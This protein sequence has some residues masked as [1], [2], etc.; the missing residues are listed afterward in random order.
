[1]FR[2]L[3]I[4]SVILVLSGLATVAFAQQAIPEAVYEIFENSCAFAGCHTGPSSPK[5][6]DLSEDFMMSSL[7]NVPSK[8][9]PGVLRLKPGDPANSYLIMKLKGSPGIEGG[10]MPKKS[11]PLR[12]SDMAALESWIESMEPTEL[13]V[14][15]PKRKYIQA[16]PGLSLAT[17]PTTET[18]DKGTFSYRIAH[19]W[20]GATREGFDRLFGL[21]FGAGMLTQL[22]FPITNDLMVLTARS[23]ENATFEFAGKWR[24][25]REKS[26]ASV[27]LSAAVKVGVDWATLKDIFH[28]D[29]ANSTLSRTD[30]ERFHWFAQLILSKQVHER[31]SLLLVPG[32][33]LNGNVNVSDEDPILTLGFVGK[34]KLFEGFSVFVEG[35]PILSGESDA[36][37]V[38]G[39]RTDN[40]KQVIN[41]S[42]TLGLERKVGGHVFH[43]YITNSLGLTTNQYMSGGNFDFADGEFRLGFNI[44]RI[45]RLPF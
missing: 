40:G 35:V 8:G 45:L 3:L 10:R 14:E 24:F 27:P 42:F 28:R 2:H 37:T 41:D 33:L 31:I 19:R 21:D 4:V 20:R 26:D 29:D 39:P 30:G 5:G 23:A 22:S 1:M 9:K 44:Y 17:L 7:V 38:G 34:V 13:R 18:L 25:L 11:G 6:L 16:F 32:V 12:Q 43:V 36:A 15:P